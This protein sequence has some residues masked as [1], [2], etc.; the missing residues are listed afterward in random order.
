MPYAIKIR[1][2]I[3]SKVYFKK[4]SVM[5]VIFRNTKAQTTILVFDTFIV[6]AEYTVALILKFL[7]L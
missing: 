5:Y 6:H 4:S 7:T 1:Y 3:I 2:L